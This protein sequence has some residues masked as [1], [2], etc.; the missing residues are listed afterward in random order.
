MKHFI[1]REATPGDAE[2]IASI[3]RKT[4]FETFGAVNTKENMD[5]FMNEQ[6]TTE[7][8]IAE[9]YDTDTFFLIAWDGPVAA[10]YAKLKEGYNLNELNERSAIEISRIYALNSYIGTGAGRNLMQACLD[11]AKEKNKEI[12]WLGVWKKN[13]RAIS[14]YQKWG[15][16]IF[17]QQNF[18]LGDDVQEDWLMK[19]SLSRSSE[20]KYIFLEQDDK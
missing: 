18:I 5:K 13:K 15:F 9:V 11:A 12:I 20:I 4:F 6:F 8:L 2:L 1:V 19:K 14:F 10:G 7:K 3:S 16:E 17:G